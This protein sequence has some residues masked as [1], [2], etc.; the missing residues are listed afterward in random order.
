MTDKLIM[1]QQQRYINACIYQ[2]GVDMAKY[3]MH[4]LCFIAIMKGGIYTTYSILRSFNWPHC[5]M[6]IGH[7]GLSSY[8]EGT[9]SSGEVITT[10]ALDLTKH[11]VRDR[12]VWLIDDCADSGST[13]IKAKYILENHY[14]PASIHTAVL[15]DKKKNRVKHGLLDTP[16][17][18]GLTY[19]GDKFLVGCGLGY[20]ER[21]RELLE[22]YELKLEDRE[23][24]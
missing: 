22:L 16:D 18:V 8:Q 5:D 6:V 17:V 11:E 19:E 7:L 15:V 2:M 3:P 9:K 14:A 1:L 23:N 24:G 20:G 12:N 13:L 10:T 4:P 21:F